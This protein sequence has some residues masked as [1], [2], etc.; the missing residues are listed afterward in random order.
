MYIYIYIYIYVSCTNTYIY[1]YI[2]TLGDRNRLGWDPRIS[3]AALGGLGI[4]YYIGKI[5][6][7]C[8]PA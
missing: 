7:A 2:H 6:K 3:Q 8:L 1:I 5:P 4:P